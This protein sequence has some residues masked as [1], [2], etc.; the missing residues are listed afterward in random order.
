MSQ[1]KELL[2]SYVILPKNWH[3]FHRNGFYHKIVISERDSFGKL[4][5]FDKTSNMG[6]HIYAYAH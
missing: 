4:I 2:T 1:E 5:S 3:S 6:E